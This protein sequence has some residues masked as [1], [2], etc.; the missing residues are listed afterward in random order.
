MLVYSA[1]LSQEIL[2]YM[3]ICRNAEGVHGQRKVGNPSVLNKNRDKNSRSKRS[4]SQFPPT[5][6]LNR[7]NKKGTST[8]CVTTT[9]PK[10]DGPQQVDCWATDGE[11]CSTLW[12]RRA[13]AFPAARESILGTMV[14]GAAQMK[15]QR[16]REQPFVGFTRT[17]DRNRAATQQ[18]PRRFLAAVAG[19]TCYEVAQR[20]TRK[21][22]TENVLISNHLRVAAV[23]TNC[24]R[25]SNTKRRTRYAAIAS[26]NGEDDVPSSG[27]FRRAGS[28][29]S[30][31]SP[32]SGGLSTRSRACPSRCWAFASAP[33]SPGPSPRTRAPC[34]RAGRASRRALRNM[35]HWSRHVTAKQRA[36]HICGKDGVGL[37][38]WRGS[39]VVFNL[40]CTASHCSNA[41]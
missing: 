33:P 2:G 26:N 34:A 23:L 8:T 5:H 38:H 7:R 10:V 17:A 11:R 18:P 28:S 6:P 12:K 21:R 15:G 20:R 4:L 16:G 25:L 1:F 29:R 22:S 9:T 40:F 3:L 31:W 32:S 14:S 13:R 41:L 35:D 39:A 27:G 36:K 24:H 30:A 37:H 19:S